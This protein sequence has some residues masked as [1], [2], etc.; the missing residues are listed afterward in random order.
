MYSQKL[1][2]PHGAVHLTIPQIDPGMRTL[3]YASCGSIIP[4]ACGFI[5][6]CGLLTIIHPFALS[7]D[8]RVAEVAAVSSIVSTAVALT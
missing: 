6:L 7:G 5:V 2:L 1:V 4:V 8:Q 3:P